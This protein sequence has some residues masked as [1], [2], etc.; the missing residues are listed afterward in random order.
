MGVSGKTVMKHSAEL[1]QKFPRGHLLLDLAGLL[2]CGRRRRAWGRVSYIAIVGGARVD[3]SLMLRSSAARLP[4]RL[5]YYDVVSG[6]SCVGLAAF[7]SSL[8]SAWPDGPR[9]GRLM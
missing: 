5:L 6:A 3:G 9:A 1:S 8:R 7:G 4:A 2:C